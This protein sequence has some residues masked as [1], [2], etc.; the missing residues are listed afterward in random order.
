[1]KIVFEEFFLPR[2][3]EQDRLNFIIYH[4]KSNYLDF[5]VIF[6]QFCALY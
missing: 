4:N 2:Y 3:S 6:R 5:V 1:M